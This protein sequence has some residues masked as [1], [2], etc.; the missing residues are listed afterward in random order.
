MVNLSPL[1]KQYPL[2]TLPE[3]WSVCYK[4]VPLWLIE[5]VV[6]PALWDLGEIVP[7]TVALS[8]ALVVSSHTQWSV[9]HEDWRETFCRSLLLCSWVLYHVNSSFLAFLNVLLCHLNSGRLPAQGSPSLHHNPEP[10][11]AIRQG[12]CR[13]HLRF[14]CFFSLG[15]HCPVLPVVHVWKTCQVS[16]VS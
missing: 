3:A 15:E 13:A 11:L 1:L 5:R 7:P 9:L 12:D 16:Y 6:F 2:S 14:V 8:S 4:A 10:L